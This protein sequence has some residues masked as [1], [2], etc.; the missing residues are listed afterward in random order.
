MATEF[1]RD[2]IDSELWLSRASSCL[3]QEASY[4][5]ISTTF[6]DPLSVTEMMVPQ[7]DNTSVLRSQVLIRIHDLAGTPIPW[8][9][10][11]QPEW[12]PFA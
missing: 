2:R 1:L 12:M 3:G 8:H 7:D 10:L 6:L 5:L 4:A 11:P 9:R